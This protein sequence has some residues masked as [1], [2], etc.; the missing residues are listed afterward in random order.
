VRWILP[1]KAVSRGKTR[2]AV[3]D[4]P[5][6]ALLL[7]MFE[8]TLVA[9][10]ATG[11]GDVVVVTPDDQVARI[12]RRHGAEVMA[13]AGSLNEAVAAACSPRVLCA[14]VLPD[15]PAVRAD[16][17]AAVVS[18]HARGFV[19]DAKGT[20]TTLAMATGLVPRFGPGS[21]HAY[22][23]AGLPRLAAGPGLRQDVDTAED[24]TAAH[25]L[26]LGAHSAAVLARAKGR[27]D[28]RTGPS[29]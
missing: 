2:L 27:P 28:T 19:P 20:G 26:G 17:L 11:I 4:V 8:D 29:G 23:A 22:A 21:A 24:L 14:A 25:V 6:S 10:L 1:V 7:A 18:H 12:A 15:L 9:V 5:R 13:H 16:E 3:P